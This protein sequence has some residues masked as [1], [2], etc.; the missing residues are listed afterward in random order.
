MFTLAFLCHI[1]FFRHKRLMSIE[2]LKRRG[3]VSLDPYFR[4]NF[5]SENLYYYYFSRTSK[6]EKSPHHQYIVILNSSHIHHLGYSK[7]KY[8]LRPYSGIKIK[9][10]LKKM[11]LPI[12]YRQQCI[13]T[14]FRVLQKRRNH[15]IIN[16][17]IVVKS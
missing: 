2:H 10:C 8:N 14:I 6:V 1:I 15:R 7:G 16:I 3:I 9:M 11:L 17:I 13:T 5:T 4:R 12:L